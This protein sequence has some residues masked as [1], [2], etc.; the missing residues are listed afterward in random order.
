MNGEAILIA[1]ASVLVGG[2]IRILIDGTKLDAW[3]RVKMGHP[4]SK[5]KKR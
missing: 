4:P 2:A 5:K 1:Y 3:L